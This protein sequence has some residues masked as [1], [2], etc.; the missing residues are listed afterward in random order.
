MKY[1]PP[2]EIGHVV[3]TCP[4]CR[5]P[6]HVRVTATTRPVES[7]GTFSIKAMLNGEQTGLI[8]LLIGHIPDRHTCGSIPQSQGLT[9]VP[10]PAPSQER[11]NDA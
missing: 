7:K 8:H 1:E 11:T 2:V 5:Q 3:V 9:L 4:R 6:R 10:P